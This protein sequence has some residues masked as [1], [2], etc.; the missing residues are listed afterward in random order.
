MDRKEL[1]SVNIPY[2][3]IIIGSYSLQVLSNGWITYDTQLS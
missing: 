3:I 2:D 1:S